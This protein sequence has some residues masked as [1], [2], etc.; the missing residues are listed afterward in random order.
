MFRI[1]FHGRGGQGM[2][3]ASRILGTA[4]FMQGYEV[5]DAPRYGAERR[6]APIFAYVRADKSAVNERGIISHP[7]LVV[8]SDDT[9]VGMPAAGVMQGIDQ[10]TVLLI[11][12]HE[13]AET[14]Q[15]R[16]NTQATIIILPAK[17]DVEDR[18]ELPFIGSQ[19]A[20]AAAS[21]CNVIS[22][23]T[24]S[25]AL[26]EELEHL[27]EDIVKQ[28]MNIALSAFDNMATYSG[29]VK[30]SS[31]PSATDYTKPEWIILPFEKA[32]IS[33]PAIHSGATSVEVHTGLWRTMRP[34]INYEKCSGCWWIC[35][36][37][38]PDG[39]IN[40]RNDKLPDIDYEHCKG[41]LVCVAQCP[42]HAIE[43]IREHIAK[44]KEAAGVE[45]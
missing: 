21:L 31:L 45:L 18:A 20:A 34:V 29:M 33:A 23:E 8:V 32:E 11:N 30:E 42:P 3:T 36:T 35:S 12:S 10:H 22:K 37:Y 44:E 17:E 43:S 1:R 4:F 2:K 16:L 24:F 13:T 5:Q 7:D 25:N 40:V 6:G 41:C 19:C 39:A 14:W 15:Q 38:C 26:T 27:G 28:N 9:L